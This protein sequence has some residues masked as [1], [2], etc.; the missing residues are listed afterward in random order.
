MQAA[1]IGGLVGTAAVLTFFYHPQAPALYEVSGPVEN[2][3]SIEEA[4]HM[5]LER[6]I[7]WIDARTEKEFEEGHVEGALLLNQERWA[8]LMWQHREVIEGIDGAAVIVYCDGKRC[9]RS[10]EIAERLRTELALEPVYVLK[11]DWRK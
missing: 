2:E 7:I 4:L 9:K 3:I 6:Q 10:S 11:G 5:Q 1:L 8:D